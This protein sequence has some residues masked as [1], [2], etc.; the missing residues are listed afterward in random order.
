MATNSEADDPLS[1][2]ELSEALAEATGTTPEEIDREAEAIDIESPGDAE[3]V[4]E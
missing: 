1:H 2:D 4:S 3:I